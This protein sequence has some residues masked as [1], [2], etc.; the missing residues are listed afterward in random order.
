MSEPVIEIIKGKVGDRY[1]V[2]VVIKV[3]EFEHQAESVVD[4]AA[5]RFIESLHRVN[6]HWH[7]IWN[8]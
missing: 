6:G 1:K 8:N 3:A 2:Q 7:K 4:E 5:T